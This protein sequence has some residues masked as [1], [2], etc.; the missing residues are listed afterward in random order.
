MLPTDGEVVFGED[1]FL[2]FPSAPDDDATCSGQGQM[3]DTLSPV[4]RSC[5]WPK[6]CRTIRRQQLPI[7]NSRTGRFE[8]CRKLAKMFDE[9]GRFGVKNHSVHSECYFQ[10]FAVGELTIVH[11]ITSP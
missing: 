3:S 10:K 8:D 7:V 11:Q 9:I 5:S 1:V 2:T 6:A 4:H